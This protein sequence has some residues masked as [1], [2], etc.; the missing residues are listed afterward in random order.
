MQKNLP[1]AMLY[2]LIEECGQ[3]GLKDG[4]PH[5][6]PNDPGGFTI[7]G[8][9][10]RAH[11]WITERTTRVEAE[12][13][14]EKV[15]W[16][17]IGCDQLPTGIDLIAFD[18]AV[19]AGVGTVMKRLRQLKKADALTIQNLYDARV[20]YYELIT[21]RDENLRRYLKPWLARSERCKL[22]AEKLLKEEMDAD[23]ANRVNSLPGQNEEVLGGEG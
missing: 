18:F 6:D 9:S 13:T 5:T 21:S 3:K 4:A 12:D 19:N 15:Y 7:W 14:Y 17:P 23:N 2:M 16:R 11:P 20:A 22:L 10:K 1:F 8:L